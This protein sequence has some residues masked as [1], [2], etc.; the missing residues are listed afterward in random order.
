[1]SLAAQMYQEETNPGAPAQRSRTGENPIIK[2]P[3][4]NAE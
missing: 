1:M 3:T 4:A 2:M